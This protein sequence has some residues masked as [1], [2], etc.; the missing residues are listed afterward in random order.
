[1]GTLI[2]RVTSGGCKVDVGGWGHISP[3]GPG[4]VH[5]PDAL[6]N[7]TWSVIK[8]TCGWA[9]HWNFGPENFG[10]PDRNFQW[11][12]GPPGPIFSVKM[13]RPWKFGPGYA[14]WKGSLWYI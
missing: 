13:V 14:N 6:D 9:C 7:F 11:K 10:P 1:M 2:T 8:L 12:N 5:R 3:E 4:S